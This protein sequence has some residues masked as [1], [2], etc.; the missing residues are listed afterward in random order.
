MNDL[1]ISNTKKTPEVN[2]KY[3]GLIE[4]KGNSYIENT[5]EFYEPLIQWLQNY[6][7]NPSDKTIINF[8]FEY[9]NTSS[10]LWIYRVVEVLLDLVKVGKDTTFNWYYTEEEVEEAGKDLAGLLGID[11]NFIEKKSS[12]TIS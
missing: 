12:D 9:Y 11:M 2:F 8:Q 4:F 1:Y 3:S 10:Q 6:V 7:I 5:K